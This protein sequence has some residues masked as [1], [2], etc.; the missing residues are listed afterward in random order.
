MAEYYSEDITWCSKRNCNVMK[1]ERNPVHIKL[2]FH[3]LSF[4]DYEGTDYCIKRTPIEKGG[5]R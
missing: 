2:S 3:P 4:A 5:V 1:C